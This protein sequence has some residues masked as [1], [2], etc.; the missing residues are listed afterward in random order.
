MRRIP[1]IALNI[2]RLEEEQLQRPRQAHQ[3]FVEG[4]LVQA[5]WSFVYWR[6]VVVVADILVV[7]VEYLVG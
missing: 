2:Y 7:V 1:G 4:Q 3:A 5:F 6:L